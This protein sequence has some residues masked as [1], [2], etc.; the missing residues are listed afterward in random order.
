M[1][2]WKPTIQSFFGFLAGPQR[3]TREL[4]DATGEIQESM[5]AALGPAGAKSVQS[6][7]RRIEYAPDLQ[8]LWYLRG[9]VM[10]ALA[11]IHGEQRARAIIR[12]ISA[13]F[14][15]LLPGGLSTRPSPLGD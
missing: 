12:E 11:A 13:E 3:S 15:G 14:E 4:E 10:A 1:R 8:A 5:L 2:T 7:A 6:L 9:D